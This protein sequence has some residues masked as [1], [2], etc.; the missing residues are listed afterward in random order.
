MFCGNIGASLPAEVCGLPLLSA[1]LRGLVA[2][3]GVAE[4]AIGIIVT[5]APALLGRGIT[6]NLGV[7]GFDFGLTVEER[8]AG[9]GTVVATLYWADAARMISWCLV[10]G[11]PAPLELHRC[12][13]SFVCSTASELTQGSSA[14]SWVFS[15]VVFCSFASPSGASAVLLRRNSSSWRI[16]F[17]LRAASLGVKLSSAT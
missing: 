15:S 3:V 14:G 17:A 13:D 4:C 8:E 6:G 11:V 12:S 2:S 9:R 10:V 5:I 16:R 7:A 1:L